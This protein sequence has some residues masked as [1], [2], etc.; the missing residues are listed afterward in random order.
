MSG[1]LS[2]WE[3][4]LTQ[5]S[6]TIWAQ[7]NSYAGTEE[8]EGR[9]AD[10]SPELCPKRRESC[11]THLRTLESVP[12]SESDLGDTFTPQLPSK[13]TGTVEKSS[14]KL[15]EVP[16]TWYSHSSR[17]SAWHRWCN[18]GTHEHPPASQSGCCG[19]S[20]QK[21]EHSAPA[22]AATDVES[23]FSWDRDFRV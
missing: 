1:F 3:R 5:S 14:N 2:S 10:N 12:P 8:S 7:D 17:P 6:L 13:G 20:L 21:R 15:S 18:A 11:A 19:Q 9:R 23:P 4:I 16:H 22:H